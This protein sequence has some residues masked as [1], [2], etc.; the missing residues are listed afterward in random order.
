MS[1]TKALKFLTITGITILSAMTEDQ[2]ASA[3]LLVGA[4]W[5][6]WKDDSDA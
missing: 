2:T 1:L 6:A 5:L 3:I 4:L